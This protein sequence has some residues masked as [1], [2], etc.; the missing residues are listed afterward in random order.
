M[1]R[2][3]QS[4]LLVLVLGLGLPLQAL[5]LR[6]KTYFSK[7][8]W[9]VDLI[10]YYLTVWEPWAEYYFT[11]TLDPDAGAGLGGLQITQTRGVDRSF[12]FNVARTH[13]FLGRPRQR[14]ASVPVDASFDHDSRTFRLAFPQPVPPGSTVTVVLKPWNNPGMADTYMFQVTAFPAGPQPSPTPLG[15]GTLRIYMP[16]R[17]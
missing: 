16:D 14:V 2:V 8:P 5:E 1:H 9:S 3:L 15:Y 13:A 12:P 11:I 7:P 10:S 17:F 6:G 4:V